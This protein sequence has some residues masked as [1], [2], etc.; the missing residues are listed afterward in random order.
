MIS[1]KSQYADKGTYKHHTSAQA[2][3]KRDTDGYAPHKRIVREESNNW[4]YTAK[5]FDL[6]GH[7]H[8]QEIL[9][10]INDG[11]VDGD[12]FSYKKGTYRIEEFPSNGT[13]GLS[14]M[15]C[16]ETHVTDTRDIAEKAGTTAGSWKATQSAY[17]FNVI[18]L[19]RWAQGYNTNTKSEIKFRRKVQ[20]TLIRMATDDRYAR[21]M[22]KKYNA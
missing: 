11:G 21:Y 19:S 18:R 16:E 10:L 15:K 4:L 1:L 20:D 12:E 9:D 5:Q 6:V 8:E 13:G 17:Q 3:N 7:D 2:A 14:T 22:R